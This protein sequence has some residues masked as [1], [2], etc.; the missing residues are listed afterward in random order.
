M[1]DLSEH[2]IPVGSFDY[3]ALHNAF[4]DAIELA[5]E[6]TIPEAIL[7][8][9]QAMAEA[10][11]DNSSYMSSLRVKQQ[12][13][14]AF[15][16]DAI[17]FG[18]NISADSLTLTTDLAIT[19]G[20]TGSSTASAA[21][22][23]L[24][25]EIGSDVQ[26]QDSELTAIA[27]LVSAANQLPYFT[28]SGTATLTT[29]TTAGRA[30]IDDAD[31]SA[32]RSTLGLGSLATL[33]NINNA[34]WSGTDL[35]VANG[36]TGVSTLISGGV[37]LGSGTGGITAMGVLA[38]G[39]MIVG[40]G[41]GDPVAE[42]GATLRSSIGVDVAGTD[43]SID[44]TL[45]GTPNYITIAGQVIT[46]NAV[47]LTTDVSGTLPVVNGGTGRSTLTDGGVLLGNGASGIVAMGVLADGAMI[48]G[49]GTLD[50]VA[51]SGATL[52]TSIGLGS[53]ATLSNINNGNWSGTDLS[54]INGGTGVSTLTSGGVLLGSGTGGI[55]A[56]AVLADGAMIV[57]DGTNDPVAESGVTLRNSIGLGSLATLSNINNGNWSGTDL[58]VVNG[59]TGSSNAADARSA[60]GLGSL[61]T[62][63]TISNS[64]WSG[65][66][67]SVANGGTGVSSLTDG[68]VLL[69]SGTAGIST[70]GVLANGVM[71]VGDGTGDP[72]LESGATL[73]SSIGLG[74]L[75]TLSTI[76]NG[77]WSGTDLAVNNGG[78]GVGTLTN[79]GVLLGSG[80]SGITAMAVLADGAMIVGDGTG[81]PVAESGV[82]LRTSIG[83]GSLATLS[84]INNGNWSGTDLAVVNGGTGVSTSTGT[85]NV[86]LSASPTLTGTASFAVIT[87]SGDITAN[88][89]DIR[90]KENFESLGNVLDL[91]ELIDTFTYNNTKEAEELSD[92]AIKSDV[93]QIGF[94]AQDFLEHWPE[95]VKPAPFDSDK[96][97]NSISGENYLTL[98]YEKIIPIVWQGILDLREEIRKLR[99]DLTI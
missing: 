70:T 48:V 14:F 55:T 88:T 35:S 37:L 66:D 86:V 10:G 27:G 20:G 77:N 25:L 33:S 96:E 80:T 28:G 84:S 23:A 69:G 47:V 63:S 18:Q 51:E 60:L 30:L 72:A 17:T 98:Q 3:P 45:I 26:A 85:G 62:L 29:L 50:P 64:N 59:G 90:L 57:G 13:D 97:G 93:R 38:N 34:N 16:N 42:S 39:A 22:T 82:T 6:G 73:R 58:A 15:A 8:A 71:I 75:A 65:T 89:S 68:G 12:R 44:V 61:A 32:Q 43:N 49:D 52:R 31:N 83:L 91:M 81:D 67:L 79:G 78:T 54:V 5:L 40:D 53:L 11:T 92:G 56:M 9:S 74:S 2:K 95:V 87:S 99:N 24:G 7:L 41:A 19:H 46:R 21:R 4:I 1:V 94:P 36:G 76:N